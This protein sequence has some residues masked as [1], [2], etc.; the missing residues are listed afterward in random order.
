VAL[1]CLLLELY[2]S[3]VTST[4]DGKDAKSGS[5]KAAKKRKRARAEQDDLAGIGQS[6]ALL[7]SAQVL[8]W[9]SVQTPHEYLVQG[10][11]HS[12]MLTACWLL[13]HQS[14]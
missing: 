1:P 4:A 3:A 10:G 2:G 8:H 7:T 12:Q 13:Q 11:L 9:Q 6:S 14:G 5:S